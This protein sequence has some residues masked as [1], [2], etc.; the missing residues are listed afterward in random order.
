MAEDVKIKISAEDNTKKGIDSAEKNLTGLEKAGDSFAKKFLTG[1]VVAGAGL[2]LLDFGKNAIMAAGELEQTEAAFGVLLGSA[3]AAKDM[4]KDLKDFGAKTTFDL[5]GLNKNAQL[6]L[7]YGVAAEDV[8]P[9]IKMLGDISMG[10]TEKMNGLSLAFAQISATGKMTGQ[11]L[12]QMINAGFNPLQEISAMTGKSVGE[13]K[14][15]MDQIP[16]TSDMVTAALEKATAEGG[17]FHGMMDQMSQTFSGRLDTFMDSLGQLTTNVGTLLLPMANQVLQLF[18]GI[19]SGISDF[20]S[21]LSSGEQKMT[22]FSV[23]WTAIWS[24][25]SETWTKIVTALWPRV[26]KF[27][28]DINS[29]FGELAT[30]I[31][32][33]WFEIQ[34]AFETAWNV[35]Q[36]GLEVFLAAFIAIWDNAWLVLSNSLMLFINIFTGNWSGAWENIKQIF[37]GAWNAMNTFVSGLLISMG[38]FIYK[39]LEMTFGDIDKVLDDGKAAWD[40]FWNGLQGT[41]N[42]IVTAITATISNLVNA[43]ENVVQGIRN[44]IGE[45]NKLGM[46]AINAVGGGMLNNAVSGKRAQGGPVSG[47][48]TYLVGEEGPELFTPTRS[49]SI[50]PNNKMGGGGGIIVNINGLISSSQVAEQYADQIIRKLQFSSAVV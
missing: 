31:Q 34:L 10:N 46:S 47:G 18:S 19:V 27:A 42:S 12:N 20:V 15:N 24:G 22:Q 45:A 41:V 43:I 26:E 1:A 44:A 39:Q 16:I 49:G 35:I 11:D 5:P 29:K 37:F 30:W 32:E 9:S 28:N 40:E 14:A 50:I 48:S 38:D 21:S 7:G 8:M 4:L 3:E 17:R 33:H 23:V 2:A 6:L 36:L 25:V 13:L